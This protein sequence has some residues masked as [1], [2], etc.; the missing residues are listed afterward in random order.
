MLS[1]LQCRHAISIFYAQKDACL[2]AS[3]F[4]VSYDAMGFNKDTIS[5]IDSISIY[6][7]PK[8]SY[9]HIEFHFERRCLFIKQSKIS[10]SHIKPQNF[11][12]L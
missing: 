9:S 5:F 10:I 12:Y 8:T 2:G 11:S 4:G 7:D 3:N 6:N 1:N